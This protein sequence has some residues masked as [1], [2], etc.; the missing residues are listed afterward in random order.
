MSF[1][2]SVRPEDM[3]TEELFEK[4]GKAGVK[5]RVPFYAQEGLKRFDDLLSLVDAKRHPEK[6]NLGGVGWPDHR[7]YNSLGVVYPWLDREEKDKVLDVVLEKMDNYSEPLVHT[8]ALDHLPFI[9]EP[10]LFSDIVCVRNHSLNLEEQAELLQ[11]IVTQKE[12]LSF[13]GP[14]G[15]FRHEEIEQEFPLTYA[16]IRPDMSAHV[17]TALRHMNHLYLDRVITGVANMGLSHL[18]GDKFKIVGSVKKLLSK[19][20]HGK[21]WKAYNKKEWASYRRHP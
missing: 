8:I 6:N 20:V 13:I 17:Y 3:T 10:L 9:R 18:G 16:A 1:L 11:E 2:K 19:D 15:L 7:L 21:I 4:L 12:F 5:E 14:D